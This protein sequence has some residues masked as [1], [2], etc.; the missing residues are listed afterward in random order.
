M[1]DV[2]EMRRQK[3]GDM[4]RDR[5]VWYVD[6]FSMRYEVCDG[7][8]LTAQDEEMNRRKRKDAVNGGA[9]PPQIREATRS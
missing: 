4:P 2:A 1:S 8:H 3:C 6:T 9:M 5:L 7:R